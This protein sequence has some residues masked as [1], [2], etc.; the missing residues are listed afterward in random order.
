MAGC[1]QRQG[2]IKRPISRLAP[3]LVAVEAQDRLRRQAPQQTELGFGHRG[4]QRGHRIGEAG[5]GKRDHVHVAFHRHNRA[6]AVGGAARQI[7]I[8]QHV[9]LAEEGGVGRIEVLG[10]RIGR[11]GAATEG[12]DA[13]A[14][15]TDGKH[16]AIAEPV[17]GDRDVVACHQQPRLDHAFGRNP[18]VGQVA[19]EGIL[20]VGGKADAEGAQDVLVEAALAR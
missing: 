2:K 11:H 6:L 15:I 8:V 14:A 10:R 3:G 12:D 17:E 4:A 5:P 9:A 16:D 1:Q 19:F 20:V 18:G 7:E 13:A